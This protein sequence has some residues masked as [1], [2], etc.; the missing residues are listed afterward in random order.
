MKNMF[1]N[2]YRLHCTDWDRETNECRGTVIPRAEHA[3][4]MCCQAC[5]EKRF[6]AEFCTYLNE[7]RVRK[8]QVTELNRP[9]IQTLPKTLGEDATIVTLFSKMK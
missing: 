1:Y 8:C 3:C 9:Q 4:K 7:E 6:C 2:K 5:P